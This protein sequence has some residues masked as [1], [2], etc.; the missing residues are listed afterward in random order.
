MQYMKLTT[1]RDFRINAAALDAV[2]QEQQDPDSQQVS[3]QVWRQENT[4]PGSLPSKQ[5]WRGCM[6]AASPNAC[7]PSDHSHPDPRTESGT[8]EEEEEGVRMLVS[9]SL[10]V[11][12]AAALSG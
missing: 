9:S 1:S 11:H 4:L 10:P 6:T 2:L 8:Q 7:L 3:A 5:M 12:P